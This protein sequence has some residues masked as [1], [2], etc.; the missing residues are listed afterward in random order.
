MVTF[1]KTIE[2]KE[3]VIF[4]NKLSKFIRKKKDYFK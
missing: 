4:K 2:Y 3:L 1:F